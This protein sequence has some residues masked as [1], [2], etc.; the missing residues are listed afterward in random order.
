[1]D[2]SNLV[3][4]QPPCMSYSPLEALPPKS[5]KIERERYQAAEK[6][7]TKLIEKV[8]GTEKGNWKELEEKIYQGIFKIGS[9]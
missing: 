5:A 8:E 9:R 7:L 2:S 1:M 4:N 3:S 6:E